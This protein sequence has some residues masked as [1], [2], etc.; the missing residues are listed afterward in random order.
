[1]VLVEKRLCRLIVGSSIQV[2]DSVPGGHAP[3]LSL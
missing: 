3:G 2:S 1:M